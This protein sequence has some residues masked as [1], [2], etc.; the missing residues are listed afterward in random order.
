MRIFFTKQ[1]GYTIL[2]IF[3]SILFYCSTAQP[4]SKPYGV[5]SC[6]W[7]PFF[8]FWHSFFL[9]MSALLFM[10]KISSNHQMTC[11]KELRLCQC[12]DS[13]FLFIIFFLWNM[14][15]SSIKSRLCLNGLCHNETCNLFICLFICKKKIFK[16]QRWKSNTLTSFSVFASEGYIERISKISYQKKQKQCKI[17]KQNTTVKDSW[18]I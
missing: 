4:K 17:Q 9:F 5:S 10:I 3:N 13:P 11:V 15:H 16:A 14:F 7:L 6:S 12:C 18:N 2:Q 1:I 8:F